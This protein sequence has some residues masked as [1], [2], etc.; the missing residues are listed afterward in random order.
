MPFAAKAVLKVRSGPRPGSLAG[1]TAAPSSEQPAILREDHAEVIAALA[2]LP[3]RLREVS[4][5]GAEAPL[6]F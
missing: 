5:P 1:E 3:P 6:S 4:W 2:T